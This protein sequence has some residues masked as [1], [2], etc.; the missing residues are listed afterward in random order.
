[1][2]T[3][4]ETVVENGRT[5][6]GLRYFLHG[7]DRGDGRF[8]DENLWRFLTILQS[9]ETVMETVNLSTKIY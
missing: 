7:D 6:G 1:M 5:Y 4:M 9:M 8:V 2:E 3:I